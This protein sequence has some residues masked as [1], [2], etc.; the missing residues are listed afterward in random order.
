ML[1]SAKNESESSLPHP[2]RK[3]RSKRESNCATFV[4][5]TLLVSQ[6]VTAV[7]SFPLQSTVLELKHGKDV[8]LFPL[9][10]TLLLSCFRK[11]IASLRLQFTRAKCLP[12]LGFFDATTLAGM[13]RLW[14]VLDC[15]RANTGLLKGGKSSSQSR[16]PVAVWL[17]LIRRTTVCQGLADSI[18]VSFFCCLCIAYR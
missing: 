10:L 17:R 2:P 12:E 6:F 3:R 13:R 5:S 15:T 16:N 8:L 18:M 4:Q 1:G 9:Q 7:Q 14:F 11:A